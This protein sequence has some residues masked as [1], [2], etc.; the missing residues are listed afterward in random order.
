M[1]TQ[2]LDQITNITSR[3]AVLNHY[4]KETN[5]KLSSLFSAQTVIGRTNSSSGVS[6]EFNDDFNDD[7]DDDIYESIYNED[8]YL[9]TSEHNE[10]QTSTTPASDEINVNQ[11]VNQ[12]ANES[13]TQSASQTAT[14]PGTQPVTQPV[15]QSTEDGEAKAET[16]EKTPEQSEVR[17][18][19]PEDNS[20]ARVN[21]IISRWG[22]STGSFSRRASTRPQNGR[23]PI[24][25]DSTRTRLVS[26]EMSERLLQR[27]ETQDS[28]I[29]DP[30]SSNTND[31]HESGACVK[32][33]FIPDHDN[34]V[35]S[36]GTITTVIQESSS[37]P[38]KIDQLIE[39]DWCSY[40][41]LYDFD[42]D[43]Y[44]SGISSI[45]KLEDSDEFLTVT[46]SQMVKSNGIN[47]G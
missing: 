14:P 15:I 39:S 41:V 26:Q 11:S 36:E 44:I 42:A 33:S 17:S 9:Q 27:S 7:N 45:Y 10:C 6:C 22:G 24:F 32:C 19:T 23:R 20:Q 35:G 34:E 29:E 18:Q 30:D 12:S 21:S 40:E 28:V 3:E 47:L 25:R 43:E 4:A 38:E 16:F 1:I 8:T 31:N 37:K 5:S 46:E 13:V 2:D